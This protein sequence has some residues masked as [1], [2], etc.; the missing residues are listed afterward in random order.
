[1]ARISLENKVVGKVSIFHVS[2]LK[3]KIAHKEKEL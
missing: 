3:S 1:M 2:A